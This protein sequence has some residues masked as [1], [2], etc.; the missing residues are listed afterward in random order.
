[1]VWL[2]EGRKR[3]GKVKKL[4]QADVNIEDIKESV[5]PLQD[6]TV[7]N[8]IVDHGVLLGAL[9]LRELEE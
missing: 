2:N 5:H 8:L 1:M 9:T 4:L 7:R 3:R 6:T